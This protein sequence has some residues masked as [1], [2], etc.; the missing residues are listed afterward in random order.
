MDVKISFLN[1]V[2][3]EQIYN[4][5]PKGFDTFDRE[6][7]VCRLKRALYGLKQAPCAWYIHIDSYLSGLGF[8]K[9]EEDA[10]L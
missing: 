4:E 3:E 8:A 7:H 1:G 6:A 2:V 9:S 10:N 5:H